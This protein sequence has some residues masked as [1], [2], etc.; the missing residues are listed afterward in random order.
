MNEAPKRTQFKEGFVEEPSTKPEQPKN[1]PSAPPPEM[2]ASPAEEEEAK[3]AAPEEVW[4]I[5]VPLQHKPIR[6][7]KGELVHELIFREPR[8][9]DINRY[10]N[11]TRLITEGEGL[12]IVIDER[13]MHY[14]MAALCGIMV[15]MLDQLDPR[16]WNN[17]A[18]RLRGFFLPDLG[19]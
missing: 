16:D 3:V 4:P 11:P 13:K 9:G 14:L 7:D 8:G 5:V 17:C 18:Y 6:N 2:I 19:A 10:G 1:T 15:P 12:S